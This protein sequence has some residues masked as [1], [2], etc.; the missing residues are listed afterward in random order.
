MLTLMKIFNKIFFTLLLFISSS[1]LFAQNNNG[2][3]DSLVRQGIVLNDAG[4]FS[5]AI[6]KYDEVLKVAPSNMT[7]VYEKGFSLSLSGKNDEAIPCFE[8]VIAA[9]KMSNAYTALANIYD[10]QGSFDKA[11]GVYKQGISTYPD[12]GS[13]WYN[14]S[15]S[16]LRQKKY[17]QAEL[18]AVESIKINPRHVASHQTYA[19]ATYFQGKNAMA[20]LGLSNFLMFT[21]SPQQASVACEI[22]NQILHSS[23]DANAGPIEKLQQQTIAKTI[24]AVIVGKTNLTAADSL[25]LQLTA[26]FK[27]IKAQEDQYQSPFFSKYFGDFFGALANTT[28]M[29]VFTH[30]ITIARSPKDNIAWLKSHPDEVKDFN[31]W[32]SAQKRVTE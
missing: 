3:L 32:I 15:L 24:A 27:V 19:F 4:K 9:T 17:N 21:P 18:A 30:F 16:Y 11:Q 22:L 28:Y 8:K 25:S 20:L 2:H 31:I 12:N 6:A 10:N 13:L 1:L 26:V 23:A 29:E 5:E 7:A 14:L